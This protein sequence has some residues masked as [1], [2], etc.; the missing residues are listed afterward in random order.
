MEQYGYGSPRGGEPYQQPDLGTNVKNDEDEPKVWVQPRHGGDYISASSL[1]DTGNRTGHHLVGW[2]MI[3]E[4]GYKEKH[5]DRSYTFTM[6]VPG[7]K[8]DT[9]GFIKL[10]IAVQFQSDQQ[11]E[12]REE[13]FHIFDDQ[14][15]DVPLLIFSPTGNVGSGQNQKV[16]LM[17]ALDKKKETEEEKK[18]RK[19]KD[20]RLREQRRKEAERDYAKEKKRKK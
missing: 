11:L 20:E 16:L 12:Y 18:R 9:L 4:L 6:N 1:V 15:F 10:R 19:D 13:L 8:V 17:I 14:H 2:S 7:H 5:M 3:C